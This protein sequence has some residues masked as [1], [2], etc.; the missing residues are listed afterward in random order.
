M[1]LGSAPL[2]AGSSCLLASLW[3]SC[4]SVCHWVNLGNTVLMTPAFLKRRHAYLTHQS[5][6]SYRFCAPVQ[7]FQVLVLYIR[8][9]HSGSMSDLE[10]TSLTL[11][12]PSADLTLVSPGQEAFG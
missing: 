5:N 7:S 8:W 10:P 4:R 2:P 9:A 11:S 3:S 1:V 12:P 6:F